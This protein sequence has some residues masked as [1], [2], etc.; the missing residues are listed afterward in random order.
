MIT[1]TAEDDEQSYTVKS[2][3]SATGLTLSPLETPQSVSVITRQ[4]MDDQQMT[5]VQ[6]ALKQVTGVS[7]KAVDRGRNSLSARGFSINNF[8]LDGV[9][10]VSGNVGIETTNNAIYQTVEVVRGATGLLN[11]AGNP[12]ATINLVRK[13]ADSPVIKGEISGH[14]GSWDNYGIGADVQSPL[15]QS[16][17]IRGRIVVQHQ[18]AESFI[19]LEDTQSSTL[20]AVV[21]TDLTENTQFSIGASYQ[22]DDRSG[23]YWGGLPRWFSDGTATNWSR[24]KTTATDW[25]KWNTEQT[26]V[27]LNL[28]HQFANGWGIK[29][30][31]NHFRQ[32]EESELLWTWGEPDI[33]TGLGMET[34]P[35]WYITSPRQNQFNFIAN[36]DF[37]LFGRQHEFV[38]GAMHTTSKGGW[39]MYWDPINPQESTGSIGN[40]Y[41]WSGKFPKPVWGDRSSLTSTKT[42]Q[43]AVYSA[44]RL[45]VAEPLKVILGGRVTNWENETDGSETREEKNVFTPYI[46]ALYDFNDYA[47]GYVSYTSIFNPQNNRDRNGNY[48][49]PVE[50]NSYEIGLKFNLIEDKLTASIAA[51]RTEQDNFAVADEGYFIPGTTT[52][53][54]RPAQGTVAKGYEA[55]IN[56]SITD[57]WDLSLGMA[58]FSAKD[59][60][61]QDVA[62]EHPRRSLNLFTKYDLSN[63]I[64]GFTIGGGLNWQSRAPTQATNPVTGLSEKV[65]QP[66]YVLANVMAEYKV[67]EPLSIQLNVNNLFDKTYWTDSWGTFTYGE[68]RHF[69][70]GLRYKF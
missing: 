17:D 24:S 57:H 10:V 70:L 30:S 34:A 48:L 18:Q 50:G 35:Y 16:G 32:E 8:Q 31:A 53:A 12:A 46:G 64:N 43:S 69:K 61:N 49:D 52:V 19:D 14:I 42:T 36:K 5:T 21:D 68:P 1:I 45:H 33:D 47:T 15:T 7:I 22:K 25:G 55:E 3:K 67:S 4:R 62:T 13:H 59:A 54:S 37:S 58:T 26:T 9:P 20:Y 56:G 29:F 27:F 6:D 28:A 2:T 39:D 51:Y 63:W 38:I 44:L 60:E 66:A 23:I 41:Q 65:G 11:G 40:F